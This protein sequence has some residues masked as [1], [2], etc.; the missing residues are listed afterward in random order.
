MATKKL[1][2]NDDS[3]DGK[4]QL[5]HNA[6]PLVLKEGSVLKSVIDY[7]HDNAAYYNL[8]KDDLEK[9]PLQL[10][11]RIIEEKSSFRLEAQKDTSDVVTYVFVQTYFGLPVWEA[12]VAVTV[13][14]KRESILSSISSAYDEIEVANVNK[15]ALSKKTELGFLHKSLGIEAEVREKKREVKIES[16]RLLVY[17][18]E[19]KKRTIVPLRHEKTEKDNFENDGEFILPLPP[20]PDSI[21]D[22][23]FYVVKEIIFDFPIVVNASLIWRAFI[24]LQTGAVL[25]LRAFGSNATAMVFD[26]DPIT[27]GS[28]LVPSSS[29]ALLTG[30]R[31]SVTLSNLNAPSSGG[32]QSLAGSLVSIQEVES[33][34]IAAPTTNS[35][36][37]FAYNARTDNFA[38]VNVY[39]HCNGFLQLILDMGFGMSYFNGTAFPVPCDQKAFSYGTVNG[40]CLGNSTGITSVNFALADNN[41]ASP[42]SIAADKR[43]VLHEIGGHGVLYCHVGSANFG[44]SHSAG[45][46]IA[47]ILSDPGSLA[48]DRFETFPFTFLS[49]P[50]TSRRFH[51]R[52]PASGWGWAGSIALNPF[53]SSDPGGYNNEQILSTTLFRLYRSMGGDSADLNTQRFA[54]RFA[55]YLILK[56]IGTLT[57]TTNPAT[58]RA[59]ELAMENGDAADWNSQS[60]LETHAGGAYMK[61]IRWAFEKQGAFQLAGT[62]TPNNNAGN[63]PPVDVYIN[64]GRNGEYDYQ[65]NHWS[66]QDI[67]NRTT[68]G[69]GGGVHEEP[70]MGQTN[71]AYV[72]IKNRGYQAATGIIVKGYHCNP[73]VGLEFPNDWI[74]M[75][76]PQ[77]SASNLAA[78][79]NVGEIVGPFEWEPSQIGHECMFF[80]VSATGD[81]CNTDGR[82]TGPI[83][84]WRLVP[85]D[86]NIGQRNV[87][88]VASTSEGL[89]ASFENRPFWIRNTFDRKVKVEINIKLPDIISKDNW[90]LSIISEG[91]QS[92]YMNAGERKQVRM[93]MTAGN[94]VDLKKEAIN[95]NIE[96][97]VK[98][99]GIVVGGMNYYIDPLMEFPSHQIDNESTNCFKTANSLIKCLDLP[100]TKIKSITVR[101]INIDITFDNENCDC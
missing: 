99:D 23:N 21:K 2:K 46:S 79:D 27:K 94:P 15:A 49:L 32:V 8:S 98:Q 88:P 54:S 30:I 74:A 69:D 68:I 75:T 96:I 61:V 85:H 72:R 19:E 81:P 24:E 33:P 22:G 44:F 78:N 31:D 5:N 47:A 87:A 29:D 56:A 71:Y 1:I 84:E 40:Y 20:V 70:I 83:P 11:E 13:N 17:K 90:K 62:A 39:H 12:G 16:E 60:P 48:P 93:R 14:K 57:T 82:V 18:Y 77:L 37:S 89:K 34:T 43:V 6:L 64:D 92:F 67:W 52:T 51:N 3:F 76:T 45:D 95:K 97:V 59:F 36:Y 101:K 25:F 10:E 53:S 4:R 100:N 38:A 55:V 35:P 73:G 7:L 9:M 65:P 42:L 28:G 58:A 63:P 66:C 86:N 91:G 80:T 26:R 41:T 50:A